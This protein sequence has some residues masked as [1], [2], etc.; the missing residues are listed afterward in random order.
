LNR[1]AATGAASQQESDVT[2][3]NIGNTSGEQWPLKAYKNLAFLNS[4]SA[5]PV[6]MLCE[7]LEPQARFDQLG[8]ED[9]IVFFGSA[10]TLP[11]DTAEEALLAVQAEVSAG[12]AGQADLA[13]AQRDL[14]M[15]RY[16]EDAR[17][18]AYRL[19][20]TAVATALRSAPAAAR[21]SWRPPTAAPSRPTDRP[22]A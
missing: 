16:Y 14:E 9:T 5:R 19:T 6:R 17:Q 13:R 8:V 18:L 3:G 22:S 21:A 2:G 20:V 10:R 15:S 1:V 11:R 4:P 12:R 7:Y